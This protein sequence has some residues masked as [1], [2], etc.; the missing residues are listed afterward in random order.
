MGKWVLANGCYSLV[1]FLK[2]SQALNSIYI[3][4]EW[5]KMGKLAKSGLF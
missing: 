5:Q 1:I 2:L 4:A 3:H